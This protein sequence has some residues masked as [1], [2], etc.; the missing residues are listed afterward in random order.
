MAPPQYVGGH[1]LADRAEQRSHDLAVSAGA[2]HQQLR[3]LGRLHQ[4]LGRV[5]L[6]DRGGHGVVLGDTPASARAL[7]RIS[8]AAITG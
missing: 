3:V 8:S 7:T 6:H 4:H 2:D 5:L 1:V